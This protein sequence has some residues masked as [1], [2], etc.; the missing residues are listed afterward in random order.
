MLAMAKMEYERAEERY[1]KL[2]D[3]LE[4]DDD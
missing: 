3:E 1:E 4:G 2:E